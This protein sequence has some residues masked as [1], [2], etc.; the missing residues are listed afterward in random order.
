[1][2][3]QPLINAAKDELV[4]LGY[5]KH[6]RGRRARLNCTKTATLKGAPANA[7][8]RWKQIQA[9]EAPLFTALFNASLKIFEGSDGGAG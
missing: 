4:D 6:K 1:V 9:T 2:S 7:V 3:R 5:A 8:R